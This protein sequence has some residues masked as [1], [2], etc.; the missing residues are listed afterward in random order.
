MTMNTIR[1]IPLVAATLLALLTSGCASQITTSNSVITTVCEVPQADMLGTM[2]EVV[3]G[4][5][6]YTYKPK[7]ATAASVKYNPSNPM[8]GSATV[9]VQASPASGLSKE[10]QRVTGFELVYTDVTPLMSQDTAFGG[11]DI[12]ALLKSSFDELAQFKGMHCVV[13]RR[14]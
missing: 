11:G 5:R 14:G 3:A 2:R 10:G 13:V 7:S 4:M 12:I 1:P 9:Q 8:M 6:N